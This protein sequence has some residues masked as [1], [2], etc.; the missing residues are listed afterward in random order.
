[1]TAPRIGPQWSW[2][3]KTDKSGLFLSWEKGWPQTLFPTASFLQ[4]PNDFA[5]GMFCETSQVT[6]PLTAAS[7]SVQELKQVIL[8]TGETQIQEMNLGDC[9][10]YL[11]LNVNSTDSD[12][13]GEEVALPP[14]I[15]CEQAWS[16]SLTLEFPTV[17]FSTFSTRPQIYSL[18]FV[19]IPIRVR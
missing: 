2:N 19:L 7:Y 17:Y 18:K 10:S 5:P 12:R 14:E 16:P 13:C 15:S 6:L 8:R 4:G 9:S 11:V 3:S 1:M